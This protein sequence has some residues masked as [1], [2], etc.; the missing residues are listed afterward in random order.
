MVFVQCAEPADRRVERSVY[1]LGTRCTVS[2]FYTAPLPFDPDAV[3]E[4]VSDRLQTIEQVMSANR[5]DSQLSAINNAAG[6]NPVAVAPA[7]FSLI[8]KSIGFA[9]KTDS[10]FNPA[11]GALVKLWGIGFKNEQLPAADAIQAAS[12]LTDWKTVRLNSSDTSVF[13]PIAGMELDL[14]GIAKG[15][16]ADEI[17]KILRSMGVERAIINI[18]GTVIVLGKKNRTQLWK[19]G[20]KDPRRHDGGAV[21]SAALSNAAFVTSGSYERFFEQD[22]KRYHHILDATTGYPAVSD[23]VSVTIIGENGAD[24]DALATACF[25]LGKKKSLALLKTLPQINAVFIDAHNTA[26]IT[27]GLKNRITVLEPPF[28]IQVLE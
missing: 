21:L 3:F 2:L 1:A 9:H 8:K 7:L 12:A 17:A 27:D 14:G 10:A 6:K 19:I 28:R 4:A 22:G 24:A 18:G 13:L 15:Y 20:I 5:A 25:V 16:A 26:Y 23:L 11:I